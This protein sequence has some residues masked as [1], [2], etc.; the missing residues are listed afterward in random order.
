MSFLRLPRF[1]K[2][3]LNH[4]LGIQGPSAAG[5]IPQPLPVFPLEMPRPSTGEALKHSEV[6]EL[7]EVSYPDTG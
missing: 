2:K 6:K 7:P 3:G 4:E 1:W 5:P